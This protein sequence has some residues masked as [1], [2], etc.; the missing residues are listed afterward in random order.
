[1]KRRTV[2]AG[3]AATLAP[4]ALVAQTR[5]RP[6][7]YRLGVLMGNLAHDPVGQAYVASLLQGLRALG[8]Q[9]GG[10]LRVEWR[11]TGGDADRIGGERRHH[12]R[13]GRGDRHL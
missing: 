6:A 1:M 8:W 2:L 13:Q 4:R 10:N 9:E 3:I 5:G 11:W 7:P 12:E